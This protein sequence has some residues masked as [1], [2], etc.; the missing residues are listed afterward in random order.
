[1]RKNLLTLYLFIYLRLQVI[2]ERGVLDLI[3]KELME[4]NGP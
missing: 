4:W 3:L 1:M 2:S